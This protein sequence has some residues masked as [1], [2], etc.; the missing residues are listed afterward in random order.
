MNNPTARS[1]V[2][3]REM[4]HLPEKVWSA[5]RQGELIKEWLMENDF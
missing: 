4:G 2:I 5:L 3:E 1:L